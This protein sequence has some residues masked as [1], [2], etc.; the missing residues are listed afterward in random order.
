[1]NVFV[2]P[3]HDESNNKFLLENRL[4]HNLIVHSWIDKSVES[5]DS[6]IALKSTAKFENLVKFTMPKSS[7]S[8]GQSKYFTVLL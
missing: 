1:M 4:N 3:I 8:G 7:C 2:N 6:L 5:D